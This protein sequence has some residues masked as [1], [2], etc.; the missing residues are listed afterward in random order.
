MN[1]HSWLI[2][3]YPSAWRQRY[4]EE[5]DALLKECLHSPMDVLDILLG[6]LDAHLQL[7]ND[8]NWRLM[9]MVNKLRTTIWMVFAGYIGFVI[10]GLGLV[11][12]VDD[13]PAVPLMKVNQS[14]Q[15]AWRAIQISSGLTLLAVILGGTPLA[16]TFLK[17]AF[18]TS[19]RDLRLL[20]VP[21]ASFFI[22]LM[23]ILIMVTIARDWIQFPGIA[24][25]VSLENFPAGNKLLLGGFMLVFL[26]GA[27]AS[28][29]AVWKILNNTEDA[30]TF[31]ILG[32]STTVRLY[33]FAFVPA[34][35]TTLLM[36]VM[37][38]ATLIFGNITR[39]ILP[40]WFGGNYGIL[41]TNT[42]LSYGVTLIIMA[43]STTLAVLGL[44]RGYPEWKRI[45]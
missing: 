21:L 4:G 36:A 24:Q 12:L 30:S 32:R 15:V 45:P 29:G 35:V 6:A 31:S 13:S 28:A 25:Q 8:M 39:A 17:R 7:T 18:S 37:L 44:V 2:R 23:Y 5:F 22:V 34:V 19:R 42:A 27:F 11:G 10:G 33:G 41:L 9:N 1:K 16:V 20:V 14:L 3:L 43:L 26:L 38:I 40:N